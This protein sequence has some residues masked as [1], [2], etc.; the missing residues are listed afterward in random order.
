MC[1]SRSAHADVLISNR[2]SNYFSFKFEFQVR[3]RYGA[4]TRD[5]FKP[6][7]PCTHCIGSKTTMENLK[8]CHDGN[9]E[10]VEV[11]KI[12]ELNSSQRNALRGFV[13]YCTCIFQSG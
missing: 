7:I 1:I 12:L 4:I 3:A 2:L 10:S 8:N 9:G 5:S 6:V 13:C 11:M